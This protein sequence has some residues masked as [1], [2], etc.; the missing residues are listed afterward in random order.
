MVCIWE[1]RQICLHRDPAK[2]EEHLRAVSPEDGPRIDDLCRDI[3]RFIPLKMPIMDI[4]NLKVREKSRTSPGALL[5]ML[6]A[7][8]RLM[9]LGKLPVREY[10][11]RFKHPGIRLL[12]S[13]VV[14]PE[15]DA[16]SLMFTLADFASGDGGYVEGGSPKLSAG[17]ARPL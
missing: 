16:V 2:L 9:P 15:Y 7:F 6:P 13:G 1:G 12:L 10:T 17:M 5:S 8:S 14:P 3:R 4:P 11:A